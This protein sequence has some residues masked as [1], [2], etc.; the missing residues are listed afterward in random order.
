MMRRA[1]GSG[2]G[3]RG[4][5]PS[6][7]AFGTSA[8]AAI[9]TAI[10]VTVCLGV[11]EYRH[12]DNLTRAAREAEAAMVRAIAGA[13]QSADAG[14]GNS[15][16]GDAADRGADGPAPDR[17][18]GRHAL[19][20]ASGR[21]TIVVFSDYECPDCRRIDEQ[22]EELLQRDDV[23]IVPRHFPLCA[24]CNRLMP[25][26]LHPDACRRAL[27]AEAAGLLGGNRAFAAAHQ[28]LFAMQGEGA[29]GGAAETEARDALDVVS[30]ATGLDRDALLAR[31]NS[32][33]AHAAIA[34][35]IEDAVALGV[36][37]TPMVFV[38]GVEWKW[39]RARDRIGNLVDRVA[40]AA[41]QLDPSR[42]TPQATPPSA[43]ERL[44]DEWR[45]S[46]RL[47]A[48]SAEERAMAGV[49]PETEAT[50]NAL[51][52]GESVPRVDI[53]LDYTTP[54]TAT[55]LSELDALAA[56]GLVFR[57][58]DFQFPVSRGCNELG[59]LREDRPEACL[60]ALI[61]AATGVA[62]GADARLQVSKWLQAHRESISL[63]AILP[64]IDSLSAAPADASGQSDREPSSTRAAVLAAFGDGRALDRVHRESA[65]LWRRMMPQSLPAIVVNDRLLPRWEHPGAPARE[66]LRLL[67]ETA[68]SEARGARDAPPP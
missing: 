9:A 64:F 48:I 54:A 43:A 40:T 44:V 27:L 23:T 26:S 31:M 11:L 4:A 45:A 37:F 57:R 30:E 28:A 42:P 22:L 15:M 1:T 18:Q 47:P 29:Q 41:T 67:I 49:H 66:V 32:E 20:A 59:S 35:D 17:L 39:F 14:E 6:T 65:L 12:A 50:A 8:A 24:D 62:I 56:E 38:N 10:V 16:M 53:W 55:L 46:R 51:Q 63:E 13:G 7:P 2:S 25:R 61:T 33:E 34:A 19:G 5:I 36:T 21:I 68:A 58:T 60:A 52:N 3:S